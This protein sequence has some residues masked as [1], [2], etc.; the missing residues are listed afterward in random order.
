MEK[1][2]II[3]KMI[4]EYSDWIHKTNKDDCYD[5]FLYWYNNINI[6]KINIL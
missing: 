2:K 6:Y 4:E 1:I 3:Q 5:N